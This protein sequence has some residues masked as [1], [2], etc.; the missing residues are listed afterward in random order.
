MITLKSEIQS[1]INLNSIALIFYNPFK[2]CMENFIIKSL[3]LIYYFIVNKL[4]ENEII[5]NTNEFICINKSVLESIKA[6]DYN[7]N[8]PRYVDTF[9]A[10]DTIDLGAISAELIAVDKASLIIDAA[11][12]KFCKELGINPPFAIQGQQA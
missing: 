6:N 2:G 9:K 11:I 3:R 7:L 8:I 10:E 4:S 12:A 1:A 5:K